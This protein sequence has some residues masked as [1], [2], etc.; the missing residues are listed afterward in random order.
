M[1]QSVANISATVAYFEA[2]FVSSPDRVQV[3]DQTVVVSTAEL[4]QAELHQVLPTAYGRMLESPDPKLRF[5]E[6]LGF[7]AIHDCSRG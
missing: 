4:R 3:L 5:L 1:F 6:A 7:K 2:L